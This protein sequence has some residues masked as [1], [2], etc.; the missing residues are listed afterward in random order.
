MLLLQVMRA[1]GRGGR[2]GVQ[3][4]SSNSAP[5]TLFLLIQLYAQWTCYPVDLT[6]ISV[7]LHVPV[8]M[9]LSGSY[10]NISPA[11]CS[12]GHVTK[13]IL[14]QYQPCC[15]FQWTCVS[16]LFDQCFVTPDCLLCHCHAEH[17]STLRSHPAE[18]PRW[19]MSG[20]FCYVHVRQL[21]NRFIGEY[22]ATLLGDFKGG[23][24]CQRER[25]L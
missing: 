8:D 23:F 4:S 13:W 11:V 10:F 2:L 17:A 14:L 12:S 15:M 18:Y 25:I 5:S 9:L 19:E 21:R 16:I 20:S 22:V 6:S 7:L 3:Q 24:Y 1:C